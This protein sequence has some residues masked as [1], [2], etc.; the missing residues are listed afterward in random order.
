MSPRPITGPRPLLGP[1]LALLLPLLLAGCAE[2]LTPYALSAYAPVALFD[3]IASPTVLPAPSDLSRSPQTGK[4][5]LTGQSGDEKAQT[6]L[7]AYLNTLD[8]F[9][10]SVVAEARFSA[11]LDPATLSSQTVQVFEIS[12]LQSPTAQS[13]VTISSGTAEA[14]AGGAKTGWL[15]LSSSAGWQRGKTYA[16]VVLG[17]SGGVKDR[18]GTPLARAPLF[19][20]AAAPRPLC[21]WQSGHAI[22]GRTGACEAPPGGGGRGCCTFNH[23]SLIDA[24]VSRAVR[25]KYAGNE[26][27]PETEIAA[28]IQAGVIAAAT[29]MERIRRT[30]DPV[31]A[32]LAG[33]GV[34]RSAVALLWTFSI[35]GQNEAIFEP[36][37]ASPRLPLPS[38]LLRDATSGLVT[39]PLDSSQSA[40]EQQWTAYLNTLDGA[41]TWQNRAT[42]RFSG[43]LDPSSAAGGL[44][45]YQVSGQATLSPI[46]GATVAYDA[47][48]RTLSATLKARLSPGARYLALALAGDSGLKNAGGGAATAPVRSLAMTLALG[49]DPICTC[50]GK[51]CDFAGGSAPTC[52]ALLVRD[53]FYDPPSASGGPTALQQASRLEQIR[54]SYDPLLDAAV[55]GG[56]K[57]D[58][59]VA[60]WSFTASSLPELAFDPAQGAMPFPS[61]LLLDAQT[62]KVTLPAP[63][64]ETAAAKA[65]RQQL[66]ALDGLTNLGAYIVPHSGTLDA[67]SL[68]LGQSV[69]AI[70]LATGKTLDDWTVSL[71]TA[72]GAI[73]ARPGAP[74]LE[75]RRYGVALVSK[76]KAGSTAAAGG[77]TDPSGGRV[78]AAPFFALLRAKDPLYS[79]GKSTVSVLSDAEAKSAEEA[80]QAHAAIFTA[81]KARGIDRADVVAAWRITPQSLTQGLAALR[82][83]PYA[84]LTSLD[85]GK[86]RWSGTLDPTFAG[87]PSGL[88]RGNLGGWVASGRFTSWMALDESGSGTLLA[89]TS[90]GKA[91]AVPFVLTVPRGTAPSGGWPLVVF[92]HGFGRSKADALAV[93]DALAAAGLATVAFD[94]VYHGARAW[95]TLDAHCGAAGTCDRAR[96]VCSSGS[97]ADSDGDGVPDASGAYFLRA[98]ALAATRD[99]F[100]QHLLDAAA[101]LRGASLGAAAGIKDAAGATGAV[102]IDP[103]KV[104]IL[105]HSLGAM[106]STLVLAS[107]SVPWAGVLNAPGAPL[108]RLFSASSGFASLKAALLQ[109]QG[110]TAGTLD[111]LRL[112]SKLQWLLDPVDPANFAAYLEQKALPDA[113]NSGAL[114]PKKEVMVQLAGK[115]A[116]VPL[117]LGQYLA[118]Q[119]GISSAELAK[120]T[121]PAQGHGFLLGP[122]PAGTASATAAARRQAASFLSGG[123]V[124]TPDTQSGTCQ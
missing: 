22:N 67:S 104:T 16:V 72:A 4:L 64:G 114:V 70:D 111:E 8:G 65:L 88:S 51:T 38:D 30:Y 60:L 83:L 18:A 1:G 3:P 117:S 122:D 43:A 34:S 85:Q 79:G 108:E 81:L 109:A 77:I 123:L 9:P 119:I 20:L 28:A 21:A 26:D 17:G 12:D 115:D 57:R 121:Y 74:L 96:G 53:V 24:A 46:T 95:C 97:L 89:D 93:A 52:D 55:A 69:F 42:L 41:A 106:L 40:A 98:E 2:D 63:A 75:G 107:S 94:A 29:T 90:Q 27:T 87:W 7:T 91:A 48:S 101:L 92:Q 103:Q 36:L 112:L 32:A 66:G 58:E 62:G 49:E 86:P 39:L 11:E 76:R 47:T 100:R 6:A 10:P 59:V 102:A 25:A 84:L 37:A 120:T 50:G 61:D 13:G 113:L 23:A 110:V 35:T 68:K 78:A 116:S 31:L 118:G 54:Q 105:G 33:A 14:A 82:A 5:A 80:R 99:N 44:K 56:I 15:R 19:G 124:C 45:L 73:V 71:D